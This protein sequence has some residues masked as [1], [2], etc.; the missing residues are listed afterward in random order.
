MPEWM[1]AGGWGLLAGSAL[2]LGAAAGYLLH[3]PRRIIA[4]IMAFGAGVLLSAAAFDLVAEAYELGGMLPTVAGSAAGAGVYTGSNLLLARHGARHRKRSGGQPTSDDAGSG[5]AIALGALLDGVPESIVIG[6]GLLAGG[7]VSAATIAA[8]FVSNVP[9]GM[10]SAAGMRRAKRGPRYVFGL[11][12][13]IALVSGLAAVAGYTLLGDAPPGMIAAITALAAGAILCMIA[14][15]M[16]PEAFEDAH[17]LIGV[18]CVAG[19]LVAF[20]LSNVAV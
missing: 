3:I 11:W 20:A 1:Q 15:T 17:L 19:F 16:I 5:T 4:S 9:E 14:D 12:T 8:V 13:A 10:S 18:I 6:L 2:V 7:G